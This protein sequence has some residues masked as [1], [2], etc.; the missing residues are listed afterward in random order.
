MAQPSPGDGGKKDSAA[1]RPADGA[2]GA[3][4]G[5]PLLGLA[6]TYAQLLG[7][8]GK[9]WQGMLPGMG[10]G[11]GGGIETRSGTA[12]PLSLLLEAGLGR[13]MDPGSWLGGAAGW[14]GL[15]RQLEQLVQR[16]QFADLS[17][18]DRE[19]L[20][21]LNIWAE[22]R[23]VSAEHQVLVSGVWMQAFQR[24]LARLA[25]LGAEGRTPAGLQEL[26]AVWTE[27]ANRALLEAQRSE[28]FLA[29]QRRLLN[30]ALRYRAQE[31]QVAE[32]LCALSHVPTRGEVDEIHRSV[33][34]IK[35]ELRAL[36]RAL[37]QPATRRAAK[38]APADGPGREKAR[39][40]AE[41]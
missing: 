36:K 21:A 24:F 40:A 14:S 25:E 8:L 38:R 26:T 30:A 37:G 13:M 18:I 41:R 22:L 9:I 29:V 16:P 28:E 4:A 3:G 11:L 20:K 15:D 33:H 23:Q 19:A 31:R 1:A 17:E 5:N 10:R 27:V 7:S 35:R 12:N 6:Q 39:A 34:D 2:E 32:K